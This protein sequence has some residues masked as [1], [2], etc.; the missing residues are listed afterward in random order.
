MPHYVKV[1][2][3]VG[4]AVLV[5]IIG[6]LLNAQV[7]V[8]QPA[9]DGAS[10]APQAVGSGSIGGIVVSSESTPRP[11]RQ[12]AVTLR[13]TDRGS[14]RLA[15]TDQAGRFLFDR[16][17]SGRFTVSVAKPPYI[18]ASYGARTLR[19]QGLTI[20]LADGQQVTDISVPLP[21][22]AVITGRVVDAH[23]RPLASSRVVAVERVVSGGETTLRAVGGIGVTP[24]DRGVYRIY[25]LP[26]GTYVVAVSL[27]FG[28]AEAVRTTTAEEVRWA[29]SAQAAAPGASASN[30]MAPLRGRPVKL[31]TTF[32]PSA[33]DP[34]QAT[35]ITL[36][37]GEEKAGID[38][39]V[40]AVP[41]AT[42]TGTITRQDGQPI[43][44][45]LLTPVRATGAVV[46]GLIEFPSRAPVTAAGEFTLSGLQPGRYL[47]TASAPA[48]LAPPTP[49][50]GRGEG[51]APPVTNLW[52]VLDLDVAGADI[53]NVRL[54]LAPGMVVSGRFAFDATG[55]PPAVSS[56]SFYVNLNAPPSSVA[57]LG[58][59]S[60]T[61]NA[62]GTFRFASVPPGSF[63]LTSSHR[64][65]PL[66]PTTVPA[67]V[68]KSATMGG[69]DVLDTPFDV[70]AGVDVPE[71][72]VTYTDKV[73]QVSGL[74]TDQ[75][76]RPA[77][78]YSVIVFPV[79]A[80]HWRQG[81]RWIRPPVRPASDGRF[82]I[83]GIPPGEYYL[84]MI[85]EFQPN[86][87][88]TPAFLQQVVP[89]AMRLTLGEGE[90][91]TQDLKLAGG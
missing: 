50:A 7:P 74:V 82:T 2:A 12:A 76:G 73:T 46:P 35:P 84:A 60:G 56:D 70:R 9:R 42:V 5:I 8:A 19:G 36:A 41:T 6:E 22:G 29:S 72:V 81:T 80:K 59:G 58:A 47:L 62:D 38:F 88:Y 32:Y 87:W 21:R 64:L 10:A 71:I 48:S 11:L 14:S 68:V 3:A 78:T 39:T 13:D 55:A 75:A 16:L 23:G 18:T 24:D 26:A 33:T 40:T 53:S 61:V 30:S 1:V 34:N 66:L 49:P 63:L 45:V 86:E 43:R 51:P 90:K 25:G 20:A 44:N 31:A 67:W 27:S 69:R 28:N 85:N 89:G 65:G 52:A 4:A 57:T 15:M 17:P 77:P 91:R 79:D 37:A 83:A 54:E